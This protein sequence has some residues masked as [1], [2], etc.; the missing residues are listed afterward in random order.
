M[1]SFLLM[2][3][4]LRALSDGEVLKRIAAIIVRVLAVMIALGSLVLFIEGWKFVSS[5]TGAAILGGTVFQLMF[6]VCVYAILHTMWL[7]AR[8]IRQ[9]A[10][11]SY[12]AIPIVAVSLRMAGEVYACVA[13][14]LGIGEGLCLWLAGAATDPL[15]KTFNSILPLAR[16]GDTAFVQGAMLMLDGTLLAFATLIV[17][18]LAS[19][20]ISLA[21]EA[22]AN[23][24]AIRGAAELSVHAGSDRAG[25]RV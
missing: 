5:L 11:A 13:C 8:D 9:L 2:S 16:L 15:L 6:A 23:L 4:V 14:I 17:F 10:P 3:T 20:L 7:R 18:Y 19:E 1:K 25:M 22:A 12:S 24:R 21:A